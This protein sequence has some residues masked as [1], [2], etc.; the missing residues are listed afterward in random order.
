MGSRKT[1][2]MAWKP[3]VDSMRQAM[4]KPNAVRATAMRAIRT[5]ACAS[6]GSED[7]KRRVMAPSTRNSS[8]WIIAIAA[9][10]RTLPSTI[11]QRGAG[12]TSTD[13]RKPSLRSSMIEIVA[14]IAVKSRIITSV[15]G[16]KW[17]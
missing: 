10:P 16:K 1:L 3:W 5:T 12:E 7:A 4:V 8:P 13:C 14:K 9:P 6:S 17:A 15:P 11:A 2:M